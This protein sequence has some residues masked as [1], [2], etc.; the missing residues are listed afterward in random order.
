MK[1]RHQNSEPELC[2]SDCNSLAKKSPSLPL[3]PPARMQGYAL[4]EQVGLVLS[5][6][7]LHRTV[8]SKAA[9]DLKIRLTGNQK[10]SSCDA[11][12]QACTGKYHHRDGDN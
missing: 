4:E 8:K 7:R 3:S 11:L 6:G 1:F 2:G 9:Q 5:T 10:V 12:C